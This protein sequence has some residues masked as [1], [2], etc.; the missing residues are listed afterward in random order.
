[1]CRKGRRTLARNL[2]FAFAFPWVQRGVPKA[3]RSDAATLSYGIDVI[4]ATSEDFIPQPA[5]HGTDQ[6]VGRK[7]SPLISTQKLRREI[8]RAADA[9]K[10]DVPER[11]LYKIVGVKANRLVAV[12]GKQLG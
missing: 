10:V 4:T 9:S 2:L 6:I 5:F 1:V 7:G 12:K 8:E 3:Q 11:I